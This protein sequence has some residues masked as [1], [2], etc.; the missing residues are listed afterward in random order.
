MWS[1][2]TKNR[3]FDDFF[4]AIQKKGTIYELTRQLKKQELFIKKNNLNNFRANQLPG[5]TGKTI[6]S[7]N[8]YKSLKNVA[9]GKKK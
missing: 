7:V 8:R 6:H 5:A 4:C 2:Q 3:F 9:Y 1:L